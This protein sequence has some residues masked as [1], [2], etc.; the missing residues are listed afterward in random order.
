MNGP[1]PC[2]AQI[3]L[4]GWGGLMLQ[5]VEVLGETPTRYRIR[6]L[7]PSTRLAGRHRYLA[8]GETTLVP[9]HAVAWKVVLHV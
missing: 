7:Q 1:F 8:A 6:G 5:E 2:K 3:A 9:K 4:N